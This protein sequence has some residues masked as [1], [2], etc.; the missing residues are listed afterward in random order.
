MAPMAPE[1]APPPSEVPERV[2]TLEANRE[3]DVR[4]IGGLE[5]KMDRMMWLGFTILGTSLANIFLKR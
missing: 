1:P 2:A 3:N 5:T 4:R